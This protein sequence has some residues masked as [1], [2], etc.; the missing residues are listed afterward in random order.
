VGK[1][2]SNISEVTILSPVPV[3]TSQKSNFGQERTYETH[4]GA[5]F[6]VPVGTEV[7]SIM[8]GV[9]QVADFNFNSS[10]GATID[11]DYKN[12]FW[13][14][15]CHLSKIDVKKGD[16]VKQG[17]VIGLSGG[18]V[19]APG[20][21]NSTGPHLHLTL[22]KDGEN[23]D[24]FQFINKTGLPSQK[25][26][27]ADSEEIKKIASQLGDDEQIGFEEF[28]KTLKPGQ[29]GD[30]LQKQILQPFMEEVTRIKKL[31]K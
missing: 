15:F 17:Q 24:P 11:I 14:R 23:V 19:G 1:L 3:S 2:K 5:D 6:T 10:C 29:L 26:A 27:G 21:G 25:I 22:K 30:L 13:S 8:D 7:K 31:I 20:A 9:V 16:N 18:K 4:P 12:G 28:V